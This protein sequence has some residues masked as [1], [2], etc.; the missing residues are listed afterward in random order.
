MYK[1][2]LLF[3]S[4]LIALLL[5]SAAAQ[6]PS[7]IEQTPSDAV[8]VTIYRDL[9]RF[10]ATDAEQ[11]R[12]ELFDL[13]GNKIFDSGFVEGHCLD[14]FAHDQQG[15]PVD[16]SLFSYT[17]TVKAKNG[18]EKLSSQ[19]NVII[20]RERQNLPDAPATDQSSSRRKK[21]EVQ[22]HTAGVFDVQATGGSYN[23]NTQLM[24]IG[25]ANPR[26]RLHVGAGSVAPAT[27]GANLL[28]QEGA[29]GSMVLRSTTGGEMF[30]SQDNVA[31]V[32]GTASPHP[33]SIRTSNLNRVY[34][35]ASGR[36]GIGT[37]TPTAT[38]TVAGTIES[39]SGTLGGSVIN[40]STQYN[41]N[42][43][44]VLSV[45]GLSNAFAGRGAGVSNVSGFNN[46]FF[47]AA[48]GRDNT[49]GSNNA[50]F[51]SFA[52]LSNTR[53]S[54]N[55]FFGEGAGFS[56]TTGNYNSFFGESAGRS[57]TTG[58]HNSFF[59]ASA[60]NSNTTGY[61]NSFFGRYAGTFNTTGYVNAFF[62]DSA[63]VRNTTGS[64]N[65]FFGASA[66]VNNTTGSSNAFFGTATGNANTTGHSNSF[67]GRGTGHNNTT[68]IRNAFFGRSAGYFTTAGSDNAF[69]GT[70][71][72]RSNT[73][74]GLNA[75]FGTDAGSLNTTGVSNAFFG[76]FAGF[77]N[78][79]GSGNTFFGM[80][81]GI[82]NTTGSQNTLIGDSAD[83][84]SG[85]LSFAT[86][87]GAGAFV[88]TSNTV[89]VGRN[90]DTVSVPGRLILINLGA[91]GSTQLC[92]NAAN[93]ISTCSSSLRYKTEVRR[94]TN[95]LEIVKNLRPITFS[96]RDGAGRDIGFG[97]EEVYQV[98]PLLTTRNDR[99][100]IEGVKYAQLTTVLVNAVN[101]QQAQMEQYRKQLVTQQAE[102]AA[103]K[104]LLCR[105]HTK[106][107]VCQ[108][109]KG[110]KR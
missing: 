88:S 57:N 80:A 58:E 68:G 1:S 105:T 47:G 79:T 59:G 31:G 34:I 43:V 84:A 30:L 96:W 2:T 91:A 33:L 70:E 107:V 23:I 86:A 66:G 17:L 22:P 40:A 108:S 39:T 73:T 6:S 92:R 110:A 98:E 64:E 61:S 104:G 46:A 100:E 11:I 51:G 21:G 15:Q 18:A 56:N 9:V 103:L 13:T 5:H 75:F 4:F 81:A 16:S 10:A 29:V 7:S 42:G 35:D 85:D 83:V 77:R 99:G 28:I 55:S 93:Q 54:L 67:F 72:G 12:V 89:M 102:I 95:G 76:K 45:E 69:F 62:G 26:A 106:A 78:T 94:F 41:I 49:E 20:D 53:G 32:L 109:A 27:Q 97:A 90:L 38:L 24:G 14:W 87:I 71:A 101:E 25:T 8:K 50:F 44:R 74:G 82:S 52:G 37:T 48:A 3:A 19:G 65:S 60:G 36:V 63:G